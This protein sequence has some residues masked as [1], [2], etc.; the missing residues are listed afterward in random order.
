[1]RN[2]TLMSQVHLHQKVI[3]GA[4]VRSEP[5]KGMIAERIQRREA[6]AKEEAEVEIRIEGDMIVIAG[7]EI[8]RD[9]RKT[10]GNTRR[11]R[12]V[13]KEVGNQLREKKRGR[14]RLG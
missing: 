9:T 1:M 2:R 4:V 7:V 5:A 14:N 11:I 13:K 8:G 3:Q 10:K 12:K 6:E